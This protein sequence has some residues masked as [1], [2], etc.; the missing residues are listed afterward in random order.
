MQYE[1]K[2]LSEL[3]LRTEERK[4]LG[5]LLRVASKLAFNQR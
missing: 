2:K 3:K 5:V 4:L 1:I